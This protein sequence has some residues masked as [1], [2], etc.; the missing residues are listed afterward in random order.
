MYLNKTVIDSFLTIG[1]ASDDGFAAIKVTALGR[2][3]ILVS[4][5]Y[6]PFTQTSGT[7]ACKRRRLLALLLSSKTQPEL[8]F[9]GALFTVGETLTRKGICSRQ[10]T[11]IQFEIYVL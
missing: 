4:Y 10:L 9:A 8:G 2:P 1:A 11:W 6:L 7:L 3:Q 5:K